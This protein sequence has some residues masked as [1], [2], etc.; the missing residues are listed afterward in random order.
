MEENISYMDGH[1]LLKLDKNVDD[2]PDESNDDESHDEH[3]EDEHS[4]HESD[5]EHED[6]HVLPAPKDGT[7]DQAIE[8]ATR[9]AVTMVRTYL[10]DF[11][12][13]MAHYLN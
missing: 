13:N 9:V 7:L 5:E 2:K 10:D 12:E 11:S 3:S 4:D 6:F 1:L 8:K